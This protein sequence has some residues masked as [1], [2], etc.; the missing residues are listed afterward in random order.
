MSTFKITFK[1]EQDRTWQPNLRF[2]KAWFIRVKGG[3]TFYLFESVL[4]EWTTS[5][6][7]WQR[8]PNREE[9]LI[10][11]LRIYFSQRQSL[12]DYE[13]CPARARTV[14]ITER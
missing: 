7:E 5:L 4:G 1:L 14:L 12:R 6:Q 3:D 9:A 2:N 11:G 13:R 8:Y 10:A